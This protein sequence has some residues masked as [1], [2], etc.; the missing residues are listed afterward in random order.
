[1]SYG[2]SL[3]PAAK[4]LRRGVSDRDTGIALINCLVGVV[5]WRLQGARLALACPFFGECSINDTP[6]N[7]YHVKYLLCLCQEVCVK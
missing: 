4:P 1:M 6:S 3:V 7:V 2:T 5:T